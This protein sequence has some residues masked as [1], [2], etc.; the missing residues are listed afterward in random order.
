MGDAT[1]ILAELRS[2]DDSAWSR[3][4][5]LVYPELRARA[6][7]YFRGQPASHTLQ[8]TA[9]VHEAFLRM[10][11]QTGVE[12]HDRAHFLAACAVTMRRILTDHARRRRA[13]KRGG[14]WQR[15]ALTNVVTPSVPDEIDVLALNEALDT[16]ATLDE[17]QSRIIEYR[18]FAGMT[19]P[20]VAHVLGVSTT[21]V[22]D[23]WAMARAWLSA[24]L[25]EE[26][27]T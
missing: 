13:A 23:D 8:P 7:G 12:W 6:G 16:L 15:V 22:D 10:V 20:E 5:E 9:L 11:D 4:L 2:G 3:L 19:I 17:R 24:R 18:F 14:A 26:A 21:T 25:S 27:S 1:Q